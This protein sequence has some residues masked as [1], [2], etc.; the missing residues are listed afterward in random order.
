V[1][2]Q[3]KNNKM[4]TNIIHEEWKIY[5]SKKSLK[6]AHQSGCHIQAAVSKHMSRLSAKFEKYIER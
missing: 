5:Y 6:Q 2:K 3:F 4:S 1:N